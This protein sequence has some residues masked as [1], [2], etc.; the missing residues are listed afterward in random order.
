MRPVGFLEGLIA[1]G[2]ELVMGVIQAIGFPGI[3]GLMALE[4]ACI[5]IPSEVVLTFGGALVSRGSISFFGDPV[6]DTAL[7]GLAGT[8]G[9]ALG[10]S[11]AYGIGRKGGRQFICRHGRYLLISERHLATADTWFRKHGDV[12][13]LTTR[14][15]PVV[16]TFISLPAGICGMDFKRFVAFSTVGSLPWCLGLAF[17][18]LYLGDNWQA[19]EEFIRPLEVILVIALAAAGIWYFWRRRRGRGGSCPVKKPR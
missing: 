8:L 13:V 18:G 14:L 2:V 9:C 3:V 4:S 10:S 15:L 7:V 11:A 17:L 5:P 16:R 12:A 19:V 6:L 1:W